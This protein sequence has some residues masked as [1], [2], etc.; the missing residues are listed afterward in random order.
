MASSPARVQYLPAGLGGTAHCLAGARAVCSV[1]RL[2]DSVEHPQGALVE[3]SSHKQSQAAAAAAAVCLT[4]PALG[5]SHPGSWGGPWA[6]L[7]HE[8]L[9][10][11]SP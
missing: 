6:S 4:L 5:V 2:Q 9:W 3:G 1:P 7:A 10:Q 11:S 8:D